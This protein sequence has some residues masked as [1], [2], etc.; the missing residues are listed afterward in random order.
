VSEGRNGGVRLA[1]DPSKINLGA[2]VRKTEPNFKIV[3]C[4][5]LE[6][7]TC[8]I[9]PICKLRGVLG[10]ALEGFFDVLAGYTLAD[11]TSH[12]RGRSLAQY[13]KIEPAGSKRA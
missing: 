7:N 2:V 11:L 12:S 4:F 10:K 6:T 3:E 8:P 1:A 5:D 13:L 9:V